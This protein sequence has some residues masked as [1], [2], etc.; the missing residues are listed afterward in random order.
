MSY[1]HE[2]MT[3][4]TARRV[5]GTAHFDYAVTQGPAFCA[6]RAAGSWNANLPESFGAYKAAERIAE[7][8]KNAV[9][10]AFDGIT[11]DESRVTREKAAEVRYAAR[12]AL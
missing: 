7:Q 9:L 5:L 1:W 11:A 4:E 3:E 12:K 6:G 10:D 2:P 8:R